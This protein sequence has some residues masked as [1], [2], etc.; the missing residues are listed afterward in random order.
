MAILAYPKD[1]VMMLGRWLRAWLEVG[2][3]LAQIELELR[4][5]A[6]VREQEIERLEKAISSVSVSYE[7]GF[8][9]IRQRLEEM[10]R[11]HGQEMTNL[12]RALQSRVDE[13]A[14]QLSAQM[15]QLYAAV[16]RNPVEV[17]AGGKTGGR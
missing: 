2:H 1:L 3:R 9:Q 6:G 8:S 7:A 13:W 17:A 10:D 12:D 4:D 14:R 16:A 5:Q 11:R 15:N